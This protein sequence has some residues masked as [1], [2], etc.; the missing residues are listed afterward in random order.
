MGAEDAAPCRHAGAPPPEVVE[1]VSGLIRRLGAEAELL[2]RSGVT[3]EEFRDALPMAIQKMR[4]S[5]SA[6]N[7]E[8]REFVR[9]VLGLLVAE[10]LADRLDEPT[11]GDDTV[12]R[13]SVPGMDRDVAVIQKGCP[14][15]AHSS[16]RWSAPEWA[17]EVYLWWVCDNMGFQPGEHVSKGVNRLFKRLTDG[18]RDRLAGVIFHSSPCGGAA[19]VCPK[20]DRSVTIGGREV[21]PPCVYVFPDPDPSASEWNWRGGQERRFPAVLLKAFRIPE[22]QAPHF[23]GDI[24]YRLVGGRRKTHIVSRAGL[25]RTTSHRS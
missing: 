7:A 3:A 6:S 24:G 15:G 18:G 11:Y 21:P 4:G 1:R 13:L 9:D 17:G 20:A 12:Y 19:R 10:G 2:E 8:R 14:D 25:G 5:M 23:V 22:E 16:T